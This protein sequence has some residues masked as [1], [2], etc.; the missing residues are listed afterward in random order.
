[1]KPRNGVMSAG[2]ML[3]VTLL[4]VAGLSVE[5]ALGWDCCDPVPCIPANATINSASLGLYI[6]QGAGQ[7]VRVHRITAPW[8]ETGVRWGNFGGSYDPAVEGSF[9]APTIPGLVLVDI[10]SLFLDWFYGVYPNFGLL[11]EQGETSPPRVIP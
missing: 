8:T 11:L 4:L 9:V 7:E 1:M 5:T 10:T 2:V 3:S 6:T